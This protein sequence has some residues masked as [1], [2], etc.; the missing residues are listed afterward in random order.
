MKYRPPYNNIISS[1]QI[2]F[3]APF[4]GEKKQ[5][6]VANIDD[7]TIEL[8]FAGISRAM[9]YKVDLKTL[10]ADRKISFALKEK[11]QAKLFA[12]KS[13]V[14]AISSSGSVYF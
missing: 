1:F 13:V 12:S 7:R 8:G 9:I 2:D 10:Q 14:I 3:E 4:G 11:E 5:A 6:I